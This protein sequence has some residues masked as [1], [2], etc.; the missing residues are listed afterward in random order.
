MYAVPTWDHQ[1]PKKFRDAAI[2][3]LE[4]YGSVT[5]EKI[6]IEPIKQRDDGLFEVSRDGRSWT[7]KKVVLAIGV[8]DVYRK[9]LAMRRQAC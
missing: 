9:S 1:D 5:V 4:R 8:E 6:E 2:K 3:G 7:G